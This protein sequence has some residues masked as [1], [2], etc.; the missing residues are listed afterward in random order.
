MR[1]IFTA[2]LVFTFCCFVGTIGAQKVIQIEAGVDQIKAAYDQAEDWDV[3]ELVTSG[4]TYHETDRIRISKP[5]T[6]RGAYGLTEKPIIESSH[7]DR[8]FEPRGGCSYFKLYGLKITGM[9]D[10]DV[11]DSKDSTKYAMRTRA[12]DTTYTLICEN[13]DFDYFTLFEDG[14]NQG[15]V[16]RQDDDANA[17]EIKFINCSFTRIATDVLRFDGP[18]Q[19]P[20]PFKSL[21]MRNC[22]F[23]DVGRRGINATF[24]PGVDDTASVRIDHCTFTDMGDDGLK[25]TKG[26]DI[27]VTNSI[28]VNLGGR[29]IDADSTDMYTRGWVTHSDTLNTGGYSSFSVI[30]DSVL[31]A[32]DPEFKDPDNRDYTVSEF[33]A[34]VALGNDD[35]VVG[36]LLWDPN[37]PVEDG[38]IK[39][40]EG[41]DGIDAAYNDAVDYDISVIELVTD[42]GTYVEAER[43]RIRRAMIVQGAAGLNTKPTIVSLNTDRPF[44]PR[45]ACDFFGLKDIKVTGFLDDD[46]EDANDSTKYV[47]R[48]RS[49][50]QLYELYCENCDFDYFAL[51]EDGSNQGY[52]L[53]QDDDATADIIR[54]LNCTFTRIAWDALRFDGPTQEPGPFKSL[55]IQNC[56]FAD[57]GR[58]V[59][60]AT[61]LPG[62]D[63]TASVRIDHCTFHEIG[64]E[65]L[66]INAVSDIEV[67]NTIFTNVYDWLFDADSAEVYASGIFTYCDTFNT[68]GFSRFVNVTAT[69]MYGQDP[70]YND[71]D[72]FNFTLSDFAGQ[73]MLGD[74]GRTIGA[75]RWWPVSAIGD[76][77]AQSPYSFDLNQ[78]YPNPFNP[79]TTI[80]YEVARSVHVKLS[81]YNVLGQELVRLIDGNKQPGRYEVSWNGRNSA[82]NLL[83]SGIYFF[84]IE[85]DDFIKTKKM[86]LIK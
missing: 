23:A 52:F 60:N 46:I 85:A 78:N 32:D 55:I 58:R 24:L 36:H 50:D 77:N 53:R 80:T 66:Q 56:T 37:S 86:T 33:F 4:G 14:S 25:I 69:N 2:V 42:G 13:V 73:T 20:G 67:K 43:I 49:M 6:I 26:S 59:I 76:I 12:M 82:G 34:G 81:V 30:S 65:A 16:I 47:L 40:S 22:T 51:F 45:E 75:M 64:Q 83:S 7:P 39:V 61:M 28:F 70:E 27:E 84:R 3:I 29:I 15:Y 18:T 17:G 38:R 71:A 35:L 11:T 62:I 9:T 74:D 57:V 48:T 68:E 41:T 54:L 63:D 1:L 5:L 19:E 44:E 79:T 21:T 8:P 72:N 31:Y 10:D